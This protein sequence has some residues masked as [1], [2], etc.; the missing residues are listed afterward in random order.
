YDAVSAC[1]AAERIRSEAKMLC[2]AD[3]EA[4]S[5][6]V[7]ERGLDPLNL[8]T[9]LMT[10]EEY[11]RAEQM[12]EQYRKDCS[13]TDAEVV[14]LRKST[15]GYISVDISALSSALSGVEEEYAKLQG[16]EK[17]IEYRIL[18]NTTAIS[19]ISSL[20][21]QYR[22]AA[23]EYTE[24]SDLSRAANG[25]AAGTAVRMKFEEYV[26]SA[27]LSRIL[28]KA[29][30]RLHAMTDGRFS[31]VQ[32]SS[33]TDLRKKEGLEMDVIDCYTQKQRPTSTLSGGESFKAALSLALGL[34]DVIMESSGGIE[35]D[36]LFIDEGFGSLDAVSL[37]QAIETLATLAL[38][39][40]GSRLIGIIS[41][42][43]DLRQR[44]EKKILV[45]KKPDGSSAKVLV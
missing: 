3:D 5:H 29:N 12:L 45:V 14:L 35:L 38:P 36:A 23:A 6:A 15:E 21:E 26:Q 24:L 11:S 32:R 18:Q 17:A 37:D 2:A 43:E 42:V 19:D 44:I 9:D 20:L 16:Q 40:S 27:Y 25:D 1:T 41:H 30:I 13:S 10:E 33:S 7:A 31:I 22:A 34:S 8:R 39:R 4:L 28:E